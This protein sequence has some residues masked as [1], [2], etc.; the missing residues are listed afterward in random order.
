[1]PQPK[2]HKRREELKEW[3]RSRMKGNS[4]AK[5]KHWE[6][7]D[8]I[9]EKR[10]G[11]NNGFFGKTHTVETI[12]KIKKANEN[13]GGKNHPM[14]KGGNSTKY[15]RAHAPRPMPEICEV[16]GAFAGI[17]KFGIHY[18]HDHKTGKFRG[19]LCGRCNV[20]LGLLKDNKET[21]LALVDY[22][23]K[24]SVH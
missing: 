18:D 14:W 13:R 7:S 19:W 15:R 3:N 20:A 17:G 5:G 12:M 23:E 24:N 2:D 22:L 6:L 4:F 21:L 16:C 11:E 10:R 8:E 9:K 1:M